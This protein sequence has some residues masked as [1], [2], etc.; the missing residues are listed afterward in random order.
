MTEQAPKPP[1]MSTMI[2]PVVLAVMVP[3][4]PAHLLAEKEKEIIQY[5]EKLRSITGRMMKSGNKLDEAINVAIA[6]LTEEIELITIW[7]QSAKTVSN[8]IDQYSIEFLRKYKSVR[9]IFISGLEDLKN[10]ADKFLDQPKDIL[11]KD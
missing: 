10:A 1:N 6:I 9:N 3:N 4:V 5:M 11:N 2:Q 7:T 8:N